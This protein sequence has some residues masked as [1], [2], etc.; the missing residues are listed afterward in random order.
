ME[1]IWYVAGPVLVFIAIGVVKTFA[2]FNAW[3]AGLVL[4]AIVEALEGR[5]GLEGMRA[6]I[7]FIRDEVTINGGGSLKDMVQQTHRDLN[8]LVNERR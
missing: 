2:R 6:D 4:E 3:L 1:W 7:V 8:E 5:L